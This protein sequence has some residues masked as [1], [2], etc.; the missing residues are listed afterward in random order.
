MAKKIKF[1]LSMKN[2]AQ[3]RDLD[4]L[5]EHFDLDKAIGYYLDG[6][7]LSWLEARYYD[8][9]ADAV[10]ALNKD[11][12]DVP[13]RL[14]EIFGVEYHA[15]EAPKIDVEA[16]EERNRRLGELKQYTSDP[17]VLEKVD[18]VAFNQEDLAD[19]I[20]EGYSDIYLCNNSF[21]IPLRV[22][23]KHYIGISKAEAVIRSQ[24]RVDFEELGIRLD[25][26]KF[27]EAYEKLTHETPEELYKKGCEA[28]DRQDYVTALE[29]FRK[30]AE[31]NNRDGLFKMGWFH[32]NGYG[33]TQDYQEAMKWYRKAA[34]LGNMYAMNNIGVLFE[35]GQ[36]VT[37]NYL[38]A[39]KWYEKAA[40]LGNT[41]SMENIAFLYLAQPYE[42]KCDIWGRP[43]KALSWFTKAVD[44]GSSRAAAYIGWLYLY[45]HLFVI[46]D[47]L[48]TADD[49]VRYYNDLEAIKWFKKAADGGIAWAMVKLA[50]IY[51]DD[52]KLKND[53]ESEYWRQKAG[54]AGYPF[55]WFSFGGNNPYSDSPQSDVP[56][57]L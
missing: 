46:Q 56:P 41:I 1:P 17:A 4:E 7:L 52:P 14:C 54:E 25:D 32:S 49:V 50:C 55:S 51:R 33:V 5:R 53:S 8:T 48:N 43:H 28:E 18:Q 26:V 23:N 15:E 20:D 39:K 31:M 40:D 10:R 47:V 11:D 9:E 44:A 2:D 21:V 34:D 37:Q 19:L 16:V 13:R 45:K 35:N 22:R 57:R 29:Y 12:A 38:E 3:V 30:V 36:G 24:E 27:D 42:M 6:K